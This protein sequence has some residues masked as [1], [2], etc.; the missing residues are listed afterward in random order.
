MKG[1][2]AVISTDDR[3]I[4]VLKQFDDMM[5]DQSNMV[6]M[7]AI[8]IE[9]F[10]KSNKINDTDLMAVL[11]YLNVSYGFTFMTGTETIQNLGVKQ[12]SKHLFLVKKGWK[13]IKNELY[14]IIGQQLNERI[15]YVLPR[16]LFNSHYV[17]ENTLAKKNE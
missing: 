12:D 9:E 14:D 7:L 13:Y 6:C 1:V 15:Q 17:W 16:S 11:T 4:K 5:K 10:L 3:I 8:D 2:N